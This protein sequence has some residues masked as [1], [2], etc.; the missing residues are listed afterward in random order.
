MNMLT[1]VGAVLPFCVDWKGVAVD[2]GSES[3]C[4]RTE[5]C[6]SLDSVKNFA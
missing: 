3:I 4:T 1:D 5:R 6:K 2:V